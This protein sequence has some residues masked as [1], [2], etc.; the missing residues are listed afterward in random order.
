[1]LN[2]KSSSKGPPSMPKWVSKAICR[3]CK[4]KGHLAF[5]CP[6]KYENK[7]YK[8]KTNFRNKKDHLT[9]TVANVTEFAGSAT[10]Y[11]PNLRILPNYKS[12]SFAYYHH[13]KFMRR[14]CKKNP[15]SANMKF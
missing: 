10:H 11:V 6:P 4:K 1:M 3:K 15:H 14:I 9:E 2:H 12:P 13:L 7:P 8:G 5:N